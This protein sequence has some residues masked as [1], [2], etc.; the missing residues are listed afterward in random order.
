MKNSLL[1]NYSVD[2]ASVLDTISDA[3]FLLD[4]DFKF[5]FLNAKGEVLL[6]QKKEDLLDSSIYDHFSVGDNSVL[7]QILIRCLSSEERS[8]EDFFVSSLNRWFRVVAHCSAGNFLIIFSDIHEEKLVTR[9]LIQREEQLKRTLDT[10]PHVAFLARPGGENVYLNRKGLEYLGEVWP[11]G[12]VLNWKELVHPADYTRVINNWIRASRAG[13]NVFEGEYRLRNYK[14]EYWWCFV[15]AEAVLDPAGEISLWLGTVTDIHRQKLAEEEL[16]ESE[17]FIYQLTESSPDLLTIYNIQQKLFSYVNQKI[18]SFL[19]YNPK[20]LNNL[21]LATIQTKVHPEDVS[22]FLKYHE[23]FTNATDTEVREMEYRVLNVEGEWR[24]LR[25]RGKVYQRSADGDVSHFIATTQD[26]TDLKHGEDRQKEIVQLKNILDKKEEFISIASHE[27]K[28]PITSIKASLQILKRL[29]GSNIDEKT[30]QVF[31]G[32]TN[33]QINKLVALVKDLIENSKSEDGNLNLN[34]STFEIQ[35]VINHSIDYCT[36]E[37]R[38]IVRNEVKELIEADKHKIEQ[39]LINFI[40][41]ANKYSAKGKE[42]YIS[43]EKEDDYLKISV[44]DAGIGIPLD[45]QARVFEKFY[46]ANGSGT[47]SGLGLGLY[48]SAEIIKQH[49]GAYGVRSEEGRGS[50]FWFKIP[51]KQGR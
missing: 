7:A 48:I 27:L 1:G 47:V 10:L 18:F 21:S 28:T 25:V 26:I 4:Q 36:D 32:K 16:R 5:L 17:Y 9:K 6:G 30:L 8:V 37:D 49:K 45:K 14:G 43:A 23:E 41:N 44:T 34:F 35:E 24:W 11:P 19:G 46:R 42:V 22:D 39:V 31:I 29:V 50:T 13:I 15:K 33:Q 2:L 12:E 38:I 20:D 3:F 51:F 40:S